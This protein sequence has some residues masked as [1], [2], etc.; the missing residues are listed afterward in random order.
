MGLAIYRIS[1]ALPDMGASSHLSEARYSKEFG[2]SPM[3]ANG[4]K[5]EV[6][7]I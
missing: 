1:D 2:E 7:L 3:V 6:F 4:V 5:E